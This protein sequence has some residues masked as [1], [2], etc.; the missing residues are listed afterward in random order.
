MSFLSRRDLIRGTAGIVGAGSLVPSR[1]VA[2]L[3]DLPLD[4]RT[5]SNDPH[6]SATY[7]AVVDLVIPET[8]ELVSELGP[9]HETGG[10]EADIDELLPR[11]IDE[12]VAPEAASP[13]ITLGNQNVPGETTEETVPLSE[14]VAGALEAAAEAFLASGRNEDDPEPGRFGPAGGAFAS[15]SRRDRQTV[16]TD[17]ENNGGS[18]VVALVTAFP[19]ILYYSEAPGYDDALNPPSELELD[20]TELPGWDQTGYPG[21]ADGYAALRGYEVQRFRETR[22]PARGE[23]DTQNGPPE[24]ES[25]GGPPDD[26]SVDGPS[27]TSDEDPLQRAEERLQAAEERA[28]EGRR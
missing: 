6:T 17:L 11:F 4:G 14:A 21:P 18:F 9:E 12:F 2:Q 8:P 24:S 10:L 7:R 28:T 27:D 5:G 23:E 15:L 26:E 3:E 22:G 19:A 16:M 20:E 25:G 1:A 13:T